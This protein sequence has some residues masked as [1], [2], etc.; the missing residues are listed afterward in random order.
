MLGNAGQ[1]L[2]W[3]MQLEYSQLTSQRQCSPRRTQRDLSRQCWAMG[4]ADQSAH[5]TK[6]VLTTKCTEKLIKARAMPSLEAW[7]PADL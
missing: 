5:F 6:A 7:L 1:C 3:A 2:T 4:N